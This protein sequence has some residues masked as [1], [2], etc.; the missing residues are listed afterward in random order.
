MEV[1]NHKPFSVQPMN[2][3]NAKAVLEKAI[4]HLKVKF[5]MSAGTALGLYRDG[6]FIE[7]DTDIDIALLGYKGI[8]NDL[9]NWD[10]IRTVYHEGK[11][12]QIAY[13][14]DGVIFD[15]YIHWAEGDDYVN[16]NERGKQKMP[17]WMYD[18]QVMIDTKYGQLPFPKD[19]KK[20]FKIR[21]GDWQ[22]KQNKKANYEK[23]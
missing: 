1:K 14:E 6:D 21:Y 11:P 18:E 5:W 16:Y 7:G 12:Q 4:K 2:L 15:V 22:V 10:I 3:D 20:Y 13:M 19:P 23:I 9:F 17:K 8:E